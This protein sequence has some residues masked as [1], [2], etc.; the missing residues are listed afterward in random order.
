MV[1]VDLFPHL[2]VLSPD[3]TPV[4]VGSLGGER[5]SEKFGDFGCED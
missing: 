1:M 3:L 2:S 5:V 4:V